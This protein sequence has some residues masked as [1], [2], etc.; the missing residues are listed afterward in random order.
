MRWVSLAPPIL[1][2]WAATAAAPI[3]LELLWALHRHRRVEGKRYGDPARDVK[4][5]HD[6][7]LI[8]TD[9]ATQH[10]GETITLGVRLPLVATVQR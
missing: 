6:G 9:P 7:T 1:R 2:S 5:S 3:V 10:Q 4:V 8:G